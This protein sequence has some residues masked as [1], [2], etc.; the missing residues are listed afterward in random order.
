MMMDKEMPL[1]DLLIEA[2]FLDNIKSLNLYLITLSFLVRHILP[3]NHKMFYL[4]I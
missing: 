1:K 2:L 3:I 4:D